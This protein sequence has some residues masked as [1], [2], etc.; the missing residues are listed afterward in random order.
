MTRQIKKA[1]YHDLETKLQ[2]VADYHSGLTVEQT[3]NKYDVH[4]A[5]VTNWLKNGFHWGK[6]RN[7]KVR[8]L[9][10]PIN[11]DNNGRVDSNL[12]TTLT[13]KP[14]NITAQHTRITS[15]PEGGIQSI[16]IVQNGQSIRLTPATIK[17]CA[18]LADGL[19]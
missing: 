3:A 10:L 4:S 19:Q 17:A 5:T 14:G 6:N 12:T 11:V 1:V 18:K 2:A 13:K 16:N 9:Q 7:R 8:M 15:T